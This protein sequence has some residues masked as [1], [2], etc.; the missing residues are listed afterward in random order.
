[1]SNDNFAGVQG[2]P[3][4]RNKHWPLSDRVAQRMRRELSL[5]LRKLLTAHAPQCHH[6]YFNKVILCARTKPSV[7]IR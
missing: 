1:M 6:R 7:S 4:W 3:Y 2:F 5:V